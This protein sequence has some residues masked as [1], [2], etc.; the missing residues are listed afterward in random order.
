MKFR[1]SRASDP[2]NDPPSPHPR[3]KKEV[4]KYTIGRDDNR[5]EEEEVIWT[6]EVST[7]EELLD[8]DKKHGVIIR[9]DCITDLTEITIYDYYVE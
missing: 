6:I 4:M 3:A 7:L 2:W 8:I 1:I 5:R 9:S